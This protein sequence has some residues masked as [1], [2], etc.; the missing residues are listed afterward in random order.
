MLKYFSSPQAVG[1]DFLARICRQRSRIK[2]VVQGNEKT[3]IQVLTNVEQKIFFVNKREWG[4]F[5]I[6]I[7]RSVSYVI[8]LKKRNP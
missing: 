3:C 6:F 7:K 5:I 4:T 8:I 2:G 1:H